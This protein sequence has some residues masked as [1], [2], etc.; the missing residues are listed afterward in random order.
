M[1]PAAENSASH[2][3]S[4]ASSSDLSLAAACDRPSLHEQVGG[5]RVDLEPTGHFRRRGAVRKQLGKR[6]RRGE[7]LRQGIEQTCASGWLDDGAAPQADAFDH[8][9][10]G[11]QRKNAGTDQR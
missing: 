11:E 2:C 7:R 5:R 10:R 8:A 6:V 3:R 9:G 4:C 1:R